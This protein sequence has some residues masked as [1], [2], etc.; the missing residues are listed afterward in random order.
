MRSTTKFAFVRLI[1]VGLLALGVGVPATLSGQ[2]FFDGFDTYAAG[3][4]CP[5]TGGWSGWDASA[6]SCGIT[7]AAQSLSPPHSLRVIAPAGDAVNIMSG[8]TSGVVVVSADVYIPAASGTDA[9]FIILNRYS[10]GGPKN[11]SVQ[12]EMNEATGV[13]QDQGGSG[14]PAG[15]PLAGAVV[16]NAWVPIVCII[17]LNANTVDV[18]YNGLSLGGPRPWQ[19]GGDDAVGAFDLFV[20]TGTAFFDNIS[21][22]TQLN[23]EAA[24]ALDITGLTSVTTDTTAATNSA[25]P[26]DSLTCPGTDLGTC[27]KDVWFRWT[28]PGNGDL[29]VDTCD[30]GGFDTDLVL[31]DGG[32]G[33]LTQIGCDGDSGTA[34]G[35]QGFDSL[36]TVFVTA[37]TEYYLRVGGWS[38][39][40]FGSLTFAVDFVVTLPPESDCTNGIDDDLDGD[41]DCAD[42]NCAADPACLEEGPECSDGIDNDGDGATDCA[43]FDCVDE[44]CEDCAN[45]I[46]DDGDGAVDCFDLSCTGDPSCAPAACPTSLGTLTQSTDPVTITAG[47]VSCSGGGLHTDNSYIRSFDPVVLDLEVSGVEFGIESAQAAAH[48]GAQPVIVRLYADSTPGNPSPMA[49]NVLLAETSLAVADAALALY[50]APISPPLAV[51]AGTTLVVEIFTPSGQAAGH[52]FFIGSNAAGQ[53]GPSYL[54][55]AP[56]GLPEPLN[57]AVIG[58]PNMHFVISLLDGILPSTEVSCDNGVDD[59]LDGDTDCDD[60]DC[61]G[62]P[63]CGTL[64]VRGDTNT[65][66]MVDIADA[67]NVFTLL[68][69]PVGVPLQCADTADANDDGLLDIADAVT[70]LSTLFPVGGTPPIAAPYPSCGLDPTLGD[71]FDCAS[72]PFC[73]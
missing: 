65:D 66:G 30:P 17:D 2:T 57:A 42:S 26:F 59:D 60:S 8:F 58:F 55:A 35:C 22:V 3:S 39:A 54:M 70:I 69:P 4:T 62:D 44:D 47:S 18:T 21:V 72:Y 15:P 48:F 41:I 29:T 28:S 38:A 1:A 24:S 53:S 51:A 52:S 20:P 10:H 63:A 27:Q 12:V 6:A 40:E 46:D 34:A 49:D 7:S 11:W 9:Y 13:V 33:A 56:C 19:V 50:C 25:D 67:I 71:A 31:Y 37:G 23:D 5:A 61:T 16:S 45:G 32:L 64:F 36:M 14:I 68:F 43:D 73:P